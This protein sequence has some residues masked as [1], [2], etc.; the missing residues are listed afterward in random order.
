MVA[1]AWP[2]MTNCWC[3]GQSTSGCSWTWARPPRWRGSWR[4]VAA[5]RR[6]GSP[7]T[8]SATATTPR[9][10]STT[11]TPTTWRPRWGPRATCPLYTRRNAA[12]KVSALPGRNSTGRGGGPR[13]YHVSR[14]QPHTHPRDTAGVVLWW[15]LLF[16]WLKTST[17]NHLCPLILMKPK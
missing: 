17:L 8:A 11:R 14:H 9:S 15:C 13:N 2:L 16:V 10:G 4:R 6:P 7:A 3:C 1:I 5:T 12:V